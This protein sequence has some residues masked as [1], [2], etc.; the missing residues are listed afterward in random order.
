MAFFDFW[1]QKKR[2]KFRRRQAELASNQEPKPIGSIP[3]AMRKDERNT[4]REIF[5]P[6]VFFSGY[7]F[8]L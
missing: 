7:R 2:G 5:T 4:G 1:G 8:S 3:G 6:G